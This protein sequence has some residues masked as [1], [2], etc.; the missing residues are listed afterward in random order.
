MLH[1]GQAHNPVW[2]GVKNAVAGTVA[3]AAAP[4]V[5]RAGYSSGSKSGAGGDKDQ[6][7]NPRSPV[8]TADADWKRVADAL[9]RT[10][11]LGDNNTA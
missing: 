10:G 1:K 9:G 6:G 3:I 5:L 2:V 8:T 11:K 7:G 4:M